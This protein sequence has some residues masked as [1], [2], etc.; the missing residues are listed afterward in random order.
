MPPSVPVPSDVDRP[1]HGNP[2]SADLAAA[3]TA[4]AGSAGQAVLGDVVVETAAMAD[5]APVPANTGPAASA[6]SSIR[7]I[8]RPQP[9]PPSWIGSPMS[10]VGAAA[11]ISTFVLV[12]AIAV[13]AYR[14]TTVA[15]IDPAGPT[16]AAATASAADPRTT[17]DHR[18][19]TPLSGSVTT[20]TVTGPVTTARPEPGAANS[21][22]PPD[23]PRLCNSNYSGCVPDVSDVDCPNDGDGPLYSTEPAVVM[24][25][26]VYELD[27]DGDGDTCE[28]DQPRL[29]EL[30]L[31]PAADGEPDSGE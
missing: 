5:R 8:E 27:T 16:G 12:A 1:S 13:S 9:T 17:V 22:L 3:T 4:S 28:P 26:D 6:S 31:D 19:F 21:E 18:R 24:G 14:R 11:L 23:G 25:D 30:D 20:T 2:A 29:T 15:E 7:T 10:L